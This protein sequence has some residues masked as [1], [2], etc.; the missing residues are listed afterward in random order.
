MEYSAGLTSK[1]FWLQ[2]SRKTAE[3]ILKGYSKT[4]IRKIAWEENIYQVKAEYRAYE[5]C[6]SDLGISLTRSSITGIYHL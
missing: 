1:L 2:E 6:S 4:D 3:Y 5:V